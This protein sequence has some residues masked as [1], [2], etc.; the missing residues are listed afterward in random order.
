MNKSM[1]VEQGLTQYQIVAMLLDGAV[2]EVEQAQSKMEGDHINQAIAIIAALRG[3]LDVE[4]GGEIARN[5]ESLYGYMESRLMEGA[6]KDDRGLL[7]EVSNLLAEVK[8]GWGQI[9]ES[10]S[11]FEGRM[12]KVAVA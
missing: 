8:D 1:D 10:A 6:E 5:L 2:R 7:E 9:S 12:M 11:G 3:G 4:E